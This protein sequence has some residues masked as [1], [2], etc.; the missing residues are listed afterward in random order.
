MPAIFLG[1]IS[2]TCPQPGI[3]QLNGL[4][5]CSDIPDFCRHNLRQIDWLERFFLSCLLSSLVSDI[6][7]RSYVKYNYVIIGSDDMYNK[8]SCFD[9]IDIADDKIEQQ[10]VSWAWQWR[11]FGHSSGRK[12][13][14]EKMNHIHAHSPHIPLSC[15]Q[16]LPQC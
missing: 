10:S 16:T 12:E 1:E 11:G 6:T 13:E 5:L 3:P 15:T 2:L 8:F 9:K 7:L 4:S 14:G